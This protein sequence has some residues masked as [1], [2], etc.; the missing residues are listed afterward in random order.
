M[1]SLNASSRTRNRRYRVGLVLEEALGHRTHAQNLQLAVPRDP[2]VEAAWGLI[3]FEVDG[4]AARLPLYGSNWTV[5]AGIRARRHLAAMERKG[6]LDALFVHTQV[7]AVLAPDWVRRVPTVVSL[8]ATPLQYDSL[9]ASYEHAAG[10]RWLERLKWRMNRAV[11]RRARRLVAW[12]EWARR[13]LAEGYGVDAGR[14]TVIPPGTHVSAWTSP[15]ARRLH[16]GPMRILFVGGDARR[17]GGVLLLEA[18]RALRGTLEMELDMVTRTPLD[19]GPGVRVHR[20]V[21]ANSDALRRLYHEADVFCLPTEGDCLPLVL[22]E[23]AASGLPSISTT[24][25]AIPE[26]V[27][28]GETGLLI[29]PRDLEGLVAALRRMSVDGALRLRMG[30]RAAALAIAEHDAGRNALL[31]LSLVKQVA[32][33]GRSQRAGA[34]PGR[35]DAGGGSETPR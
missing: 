26:I 16:A 19:S 21:A 29:E 9:G 35:L 32:N 34:A 3:P 20:G 7:P 23:A 14:V 6:P 31:L 33:E 8:D 28:H 12:S 11:F 17:K 30:E 1:D 15:T 4:F 27:R 25:A 18:F 2:E 5:R 22:A 10:P 13:G 24:I